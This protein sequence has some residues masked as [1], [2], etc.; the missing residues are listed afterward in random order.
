MIRK[1]FEPLEYATND[2]RAKKAVGRY[3]LRS[4]GDIN[5]EEDYGVDIKHSVGS[6]IFYHE[7]EVKNVWR[8]EWPSSWSTIHIPE[9]KKRLLDRD[10]F[11]WIL[12]NDLLEAFYTEGRNLQYQ[13][14]EEVPNYKVSNGEKFFCIPIDK[15]RRVML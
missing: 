2:L 10:I 12:R 13:Y 6:N 11:F 3:L 14:L 15:F 7:V 1:Q 9:R 5:F 8:D 4:G